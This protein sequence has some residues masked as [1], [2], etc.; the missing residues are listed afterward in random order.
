MISRKLLT[1]YFHTLMIPSHEAVTRKHWDAIHEV[2]SSIDPT[3]PGAGWSVADG[4]SSSPVII[5]LLDL[6]QTS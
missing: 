6:V 1:F 5:V 3:W 4:G 2:I